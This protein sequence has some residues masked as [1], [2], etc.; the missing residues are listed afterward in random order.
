M[1]STDGWSEWALAAVAAQSGTDIKFAAVTATIDIDMGDKDFESIAMLSGARM[2]KF[3]PETDT[4][5]TLEM[6][7]EEAGSGDISAATT[8]TGVFDLLHAEDTTQPYS[9]VAATARTKYR[10]C[11]LWTDKTTETDA[12]AQ[13]I[14]PTN[15]AIR[16]VAADGYFISAKPSFTD[17]IL[18]WTVKYKVPPF[19]SAGNENIMVESVYSSSTTY[20]MTAL[21]SYTS[22]VKW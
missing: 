21:Q 19:D 8:G 22:T 13:I 7:P 1:A 10:L 3:I 15:Q 5:V 17:G 6:Y 20:T 4:T 11:I 18:K 2:V 16:F 9:I 12:T 14:A